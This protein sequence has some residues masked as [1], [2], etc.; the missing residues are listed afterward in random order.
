VA[1]VIVRKA[2]YDSILLKKEIFSMLERIVGTRICSG[3]KV[4]LKANM[5]SP[6]APGS[7]ILTHPL[8]VRAAAEYVLEKCGRPVLSD[9]PALGKFNHILKTGGFKDILNDL[10]VVCTEFRESVE[11][12]V[13]PPFGKIEIAKDALE[14]DLMIN[15]PKLKTHSQMLL[16]LGV[17]NTFGCIVGLRKV[18]W[19]MKTGVNSRMFARLIAQIHKRIAP[20]VT[21]LDGITALEGE[22]PGRG[23]RPRHLGILM[24][25]ESA[26]ALDM[27]VCRMFGLETSRLPTAMA[28]GELGIIPDS[29]DIDGQLSEISDFE[30]PR[31]TSLVY[32]PR[33]LQNL[34]RRY[35]LKK[36]VVDAEAC[37]L[38]AECVH[39][40]PAHAIARESDGLAFAYDRCIRCYCCIEIC[41][42]GALSARET[43]TGKLLRQ[44]IERN[45]R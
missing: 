12:D 11:T 26:V 16:T 19:H 22:G 10:D 24:A 5:L 13:G 42:Q 7:A 2:S 3:S 20:A 37:S 17:K 33:P 1:L 28:S 29:I 45:S 18:E 8:V 34:M 43:P 36:P 4:L 41:P 35:L 39:F 31:G 9:S 30:M 40:C 44:V 27:A 25:S 14:A 23:G 32:G 6:S 21:L 15:L 38:C